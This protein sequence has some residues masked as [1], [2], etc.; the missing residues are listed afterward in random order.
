MTK[1]FYSALSILFIFAIITPSAQAAKSSGGG[2]ST[3]PLGIDISWPQCGK[4]IPKTQAF[5]IVGINGGLATTTNPCLKDQ[6]I[7]ASKSVGGTSQEKIQLYVNTANPGG[8]GTASWPVNNVDPSGNV[9]TNPYGLCDNS[10]SLACA[11]QYGWNRSVENIT[12]RFIPAASLAGVAT[13][14][15]SYVW[16]LDVELENTWKESGSTFDTQSNVADIEGMT[17]HLKSVGA[18]VG[19]YSTTYQWGVIVGN[20]VSSTSN[21]N[22]L[23]NWRPGGASLSTAKQACTAAPL[24]KGGKVILTQFVSKNLDYNYACL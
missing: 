3:T 21:L 15:A 19:I 5:G 7:W 9:T 6:L 12:I 24:T 8:L 4:T 20:S 23:P 16:W 14:P 17:A 10:D 22:G 2:A 13:N 1:L 18:R 11:W